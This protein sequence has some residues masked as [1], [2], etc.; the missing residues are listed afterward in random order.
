M[1]NHD[2]IYEQEAQKYHQLI[3]T[4]QDLH[5]YIDAIRAYEGLDIVDIGA[6]TGRLTTV[7]APKAGSIIALDASASML[8]VTADRLRQAGLANWQTAVADHRKLPLADGSADLIVAGW[9]ICYLGS[10]NVPDW[11]TNIRTVMRELTRILRPGGTIIIIETLGT[12]TATPSPPDFLQS[13]YTAL[14]QEYGFSRQVIRTDLVFD[15]IEEAER[16]TRF[17]FGDGIADQVVENNWITVP[18]CAGIWWRHADSH[19]MHK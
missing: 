4:Q 2:E 15:S 18:E 12:G 17:F 5:T 19:M 11:Q 9:S 7:L 14:E 1:P 16:L 3:S 6:G 8:A 10:T 13:Y